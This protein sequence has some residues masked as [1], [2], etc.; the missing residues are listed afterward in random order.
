MSVANIT[1]VG[2]VGGDPETRYTQSGVMYVSFSVAV[3]IR[4]N[5]PSG[6]PLEK[7]NWYRVT[8]WRKLAE[9]LDNLA[10]QGAMRKGR[11]VYVQGRL[12]QREWQDQQGQTRYSLDLTANEFQL[13]GSRA[14]GDAS[15]PG[16]REFADASPS[17]SGGF[18]PQD[19]DEIPF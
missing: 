8:A 2:N 10:Q 18:E 6:Q 14:D 17:E 1:I 16:R 12:E 7:T 11:Q 9:V 5:D 4:R 19:I 3:N 15:S 13:L